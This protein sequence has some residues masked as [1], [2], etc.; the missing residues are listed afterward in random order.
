MTEIGTLPLDGAR[1]LEIGCENGWFAGQ[2]KGHASYLGLDPSPEMV[3]AAEKA[4]P[5]GRFVAADFLSWEPP[6]ERFDLVLF[7]DK[8]AHMPQQD[9]VI[10]KMASLIKPGGHLV[11]TTENPFVYSRICWVRPPA[12]GQFR[13][14]LTE[15]ELHR[16]LDASGLSRLRSY[17]VLPAGEL[18]ILKIINA[19]KLNQPAQLVIPE[20][21]ITGAKERCGLGQ[22]RVVIARRNTDS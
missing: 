9:A 18:G 2:L 7:V 17:T 1:V 6:D 5:S 8:I 11:L 22:F 14:W 19:R 3:A 12:E 16:M 20:R 21:W 4:F 15:D 10:A 13:R